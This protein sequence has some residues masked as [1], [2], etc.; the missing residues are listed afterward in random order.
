MVKTPPFIVH[1]S[2]A[3]LATP[4]SKKVGVVIVAIYDLDWVIYYF[5]TPMIAN[6]SALT[7]S[8]RSCS[9]ASSFLTRSFSERKRKTSLYSASL[10]AIT[11]SISASFD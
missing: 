8:K 5:P 6:R 3:V 10:F 2:P 1:A 7:L 11:E 4:L 9:S